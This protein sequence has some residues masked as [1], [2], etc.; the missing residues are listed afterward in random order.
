MLFIPGQFKAL[1]STHTICNY[2]NHGQYFFRVSLTSLFD[3]FVPSSSVAKIHPF[4]Q[5]QDP[6]PSVGRKSE[7]GQIARLAT[8]SLI[9][10]NSYQLEPD[11]HL[12]TAKT[13]I[14]KNCSRSNSPKAK[15]ASVLDPILVYG[16]HPLKRRFSSLVVP[17]NLDL[18]HLEFQL[19]RSFQIICLDTTLWIVVV[20]CSWVVPLINWGGFALKQA[21]GISKSPNPWSDRNN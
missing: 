21:P 8:K 20:G 10:V 19:A 16:S 9:H 2:D 1:L 14:Q 5:H 17:A 13:F 4:Q 18:Q 6:A 11:I 12:P 15:R 3:V 7:F